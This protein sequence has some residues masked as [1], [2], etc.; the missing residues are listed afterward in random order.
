VGYKVDPFTF[1]Y[2]RRALPQRQKDIVDKKLALTLMPP[3]IRQIFKQLKPDLSNIDE[4]KQNVS[5]L[6]Y[7]EYKKEVS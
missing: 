2:L 4:L 6:I 3:S 1:R 5:N 7:E